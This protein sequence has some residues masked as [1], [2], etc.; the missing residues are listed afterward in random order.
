LK[1]LPFRSFTLRENETWKILFKK[2][3]PRR[4]AQLHQNFLDGLKT[5]NITA[6]KIPD[7]EEINRILSAKTGFQGVPVEG[8]KEAPDFFTMLKNR[9]FPIGNF[10]R[11][12]DDLSYTPAPDVFHDLYGHLPFLADKNYADF[13]ENF[14]KK[15]SKYFKLPAILKQF[16]RLFWFGVE[17]PLV[18]TPKG[19]RI[20]G[21]GIAS[22]FTECEYAL[23]DKPQVMPF[24]VETIRF[25]EYR[26]D[27]I[28]K[29]LFILKT[30]DQLYSCLDHF[31]P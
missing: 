20:F 11:D 6:D 23:S 9:E 29:R 4:E 21:G 5:L 13:C 7:L 19:K 17:F 28:Q 15:A 10:I 14:G 3:T 30:P 26:I 8:L 2:Q 22:S 24:D 16:E 1:R 25:Q 18:E 27:Q 31:D 12:K